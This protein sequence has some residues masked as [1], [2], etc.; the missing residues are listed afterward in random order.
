MGLSVC[1]VAIVA[2]SVEVVWANLTEWDRFSEWA[3]VRVE[4]LEPQ[5]PAAAGQIVHLTGMGLRF[6]F[7]I[8]TVDPARHQ[9]DGHVFFPFGL[10]QKSRIACT[11]IDAASCRV[12]YG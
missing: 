9:I 1:P 3:D 7:K 12:Q 5:G 4:R 8:E 2:A 11:P 6:T 10:Q